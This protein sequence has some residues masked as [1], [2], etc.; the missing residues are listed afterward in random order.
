MAE[1]DETTV[2]VVNLARSPDHATRSR[3]AR[4]SGRSRCECSI[5]ALRAWIRARTVAPAS[6]PT[7]VAPTTGATRIS[8]AEEPIGASLLARAG[9]ATDSPRASRR[10]TSTDNPTQCRRDTDGRNRRF[11]RN[12][13]D[14]SRVSGMRRAKSPRATRSDPARSRLPPR[15]CPS[16]PSQQVEWKRPPTC[17]VSASRL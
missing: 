9:S 7:K 12:Y 3:L 15:G 2:V 16:P 5:S 17:F 10:L 4:G 13:R 1:P 11:S 6:S 8:N 14:F